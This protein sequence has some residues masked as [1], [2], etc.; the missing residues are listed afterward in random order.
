MDPLDRDEVQRRRHKSPLTAC[1]WA[2]EALADLGKA[3]KQMMVVVDQDGVVLWRGGDR[4]VLGL[5][6]QMIFVEGAIWNIEHAG[7]NGI[8][9]ALTTKRTVT[10]C[11]WEHYVQAQHGLSC[12]AAPVRSPQ[13]GRTLCILNLTG[14][15]P[16]IH[17]AIRREID[18]LAMR[19]HRQLHLIDTHA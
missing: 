6:D 11:R 15:E 14:T 4:K 2:L 13:D 17:P 9:L 19:L 3:T 8:A 16:A 1:P 5:A 18:T 7:P 10:V 12:V